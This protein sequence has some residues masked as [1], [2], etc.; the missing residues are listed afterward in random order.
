M[1]APDLPQQFWLTNQAG[2]HFIFLA[3]VERTEPRRVTLLVERVNCEALQRGTGTPAPRPLNREPY[4]EVELLAHGEASVRFGNRIEVANGTDRDGYLRL[5]GDGY[6]EHVRLMRW[7][8]ALWGDL[9]PDAAGHL[10]ELD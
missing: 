1:S 8:Y 7:I 9:L 2:T 10:A 6:R 3:T 5:D 4:A